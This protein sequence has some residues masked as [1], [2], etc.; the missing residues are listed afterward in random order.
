MNIRIYKNALPHAETVMLHFFDYTNNPK[1]TVGTIK[2]FVISV[3]LEDA[4]NAIV[5][6][7]GFI[8]VATVALLFLNSY[9]FRSKF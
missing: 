1:C 3:Q 8:A 7:V 2:I 4:D 9:A 5:Y 6:R